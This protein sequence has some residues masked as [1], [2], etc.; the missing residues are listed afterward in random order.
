MKYRVIQNAFISGELSSKLDARTDIKEYKT[1]VA[2]LENFLVHRQGGVS[3][4][5]G[6]KY[7]ANYGSVT[8]TASLKL[9]PFI[10][11]KTE[12]YVVTIEIVTVDS[13]KIRIFNNAGTEVSVSPSTVTIGGTSGVDGVS[14]SPGRGLPNLTDSVYDFTAIQSA[15]VMFLTHSDGVMAPLVIVRTSADNF[16]VQL[17]QKYFFEGLESFL[18][19]GVTCLILLTP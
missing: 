16:I 9:L 7:K 1:G 13:I 10:Y 11:S 18:C 3:R 12:A 2:Q 5:P 4:R 6:F 14:S 19:H 17:Y 15:D 8:S